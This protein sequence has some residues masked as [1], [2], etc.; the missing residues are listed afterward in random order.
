MRWLT[1]WFS[2]R[3]RSDRPTALWLYVACGRCGEA[4]SVRLDRR[5]D[6]ASEMREPGEEGPAYTMNKDIVGTRCFQRIAIDVGFDQSL[7]IV[8]HHVRGG[9]WLTADAYQAAS[10]G[11]QGSPAP[12]EN[13]AG[14]APR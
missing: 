2:R 11:L 8:E 12:P 6:L 5:Y 4:I 13:D 14:S 10:A 9:R 1:R 3:S 7:Q